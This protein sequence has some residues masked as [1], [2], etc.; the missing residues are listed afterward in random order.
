MNYKHGQ[1]ESRLYHTWNDMIR[2][3]YNIKHKSYRNY[4]LCGIKVDREWVGNFLVFQERALVNGY[5]D[6]LT[7]D[8]IDNGNPS[9]CA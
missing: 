1:S 2:R 8:R 4:G 6:N 9:I 3:C 5:Q 7:I